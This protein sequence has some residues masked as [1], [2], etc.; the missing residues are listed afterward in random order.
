[1]DNVL[2]DP[3]RSG[4]RRAPESALAEELSPAERNSL[5]ERLKVLPPLN[6]L[7]ERSTSSAAGKESAKWHSDETELAESEAR[8]GIRD[9][10]R[11]RL[12]WAKL[13]W[14]LTF[15]G[16][17]LGVT[18]L[19]PNMV[20]Q[21]QYASARGK[22]RAEHELA[23]EELKDQPL[24]QLSRASQ[25]VSQRVGPSVVHITAQ[26][27]MNKVAIAGGPLGGAWRIP[28]D[29]QGSGFVLDREGHIVTNHHVIDGAKEIEVF[30]SDGRRAMAQ[31]IGQDRETDLALLKI[32]AD[33]LIPADWGESDDAEVG[34]MVWAVGSPF[35]LQ[36]SVTS[37]II[38]GKHRTGM[39]RSPYQD[40]LQTDAAVN[41]GNSGGPLVDIQ[42]RVIGVNTAIV[43]DA[44]QGI[45]FAIPSHIA[46]Q[47]IT[48]LKTEG[49]VRRGW[50]GVELADVAI[51]ATNLPTANSA[52][53]AAKGAMVL[54]V[55]NTPKQPSPAYE[56]GIMEGDIVLSWDN[57]EVTTPTELR[58]FVAQTKIG[59]R[60]KATVN[61][62]G[63]LLELEVAVGERPAQL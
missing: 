2:N 36:R 58:Q 51:A 46:R 24:A 50:L 9:E 30:L 38:S 23:K 37:G 33:G 31:I 29:G 56:A 5:V 32:D 21:I 10:L 55:I 7:P 19:V 6:A 61:R 4:N 16:V 62:N 52:T 42:G 15:L 18:Y 1:M 44:Y 54:R 14:L 45:S 60:V 28:H 53:P 34:S 43:G 22:Q 35:G 63:N 13:L 40:F 48:R 49:L 47:I 57:R 8:P 20:E 3:E 25:L 11:I 41:P 17:L 27:N 12:A 59:T 39:S 26:T